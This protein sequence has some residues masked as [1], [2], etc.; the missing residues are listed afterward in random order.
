MTTWALVQNN[1]IQV[2]PR[3]WNR[4]VFEGWLQEEMGIV[5][6]VPPLPDQAIYQID[7]VTAI[8]EVT[9]SDPPAY[10][11]RTQPPAGPWLTVQPTSVTGTWTIQDLDLPAARVNLK[12]ALSANRYLREVGGTTAQI[13]GR[14]VPLDTDRVT[15]QIWAN[16]LVA[17]LSNVSYKFSS[18]I[19]LTLSQADIQ[20]IAGVLI[21]KV[22]GDFDWEKSVI[23]LIDAAPDIAT[24]N[25]IDVGDP[26]PPTPSTPPTTPGAP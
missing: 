22:Q 8:V 15:R 20:T 11:P 25:G 5:Y 3:D 12:G 1:Q 18:D 10:N 24:L 21:A 14:T 19:W 4:W 16:M 26:P 2:G 6:P 7:P 9:I 23:D 17:N 13:Q